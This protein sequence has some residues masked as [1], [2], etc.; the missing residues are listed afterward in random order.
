MTVPVISTKT[1][2][3]QS[4]PNLIARPRLHEKLRNSDSSKLILISAPA[5]YGKTTVLS[6]WRMESG[7]PSAWVSLDKDDN[8]PIRF[9]IYIAKAFN[10][11]STELGENTLSLLRSTRLPSLETI[12]AIL[13]NELSDFHS[14]IQLFLDDY[15]LIEEPAIH[16]LVSFM[17]EHIPQNVKF[18]LACRSDPP[19]QLSRLR[20]LGQLVEI[21]QEDLQ[22]NLEEST[23]LM[24]RFSGLSLD[25]DQISSLEIRT[26]GWVTGLHLA[27][28][29]MQHKPDL[30]GFI[31]EFSG[32]HHYIIDY[33]M[34]EVYSQ[35]TPELRKFLVETS[36][37]DRFTSDLCDE[38]TDRNDSSLFIEKL[39]KGNLFL[40]PLDDHRVWYR[41]HQ[42]FRDFLSS[43][44]SKNEIYDLYTKAVRWLL[45]KGLSGEAVNYSIL[46]GDLDLM[47]EAVSQ[48]SFEALNQGEFMT[49]LRWLHQ[50]PEEVITGNIILSLCKG[51]VLFFTTTHDKA[52]MYLDAAEKILSPNTSAS[53]RGRFL[54]LKAHLAICSDQL[55]PCIGY[56]REALETLDH[57][58]LFFRN[59]TLNI[60]GQVLEMKG[61]VRSAAEIYQ[62]AFDSGWR[63]GDQ[64]GALVAFTNLIFSLNE[65]GMHREAVSLC[66][67]AASGPSR[68][69]KHGIILSDA[70]YL[71]WGLLAYE[72]NDLETAM[73]YTNRGLDLIKV[74]NFPPG[75]LWG[76]N[77]ISR[78]HLRRKEYDQARGVIGEGKKLANELGLNY[79]HGIWFEAMEAQICMETG[80]LKSAGKWADKTGFHSQ[81][82][83]HYWI[84]Y[85]YFIYIRVLLT[86]GRLQ[87]AETLL[88]S[89]EVTVSQEARN[90]KLIS[91]YLL[92]ARLLETQNHS[93]HALEKVVRAMELAAPE[94]YR[95]AFLEDGLHLLPLLQQARSSAPAFVDELLFV[96]KGADHPTL[97]TAELIDPLTEREQEVL[98]LV[99]RGLSN[100]EIADYLVVSLGT[101]KKHLN[102]IFGKLH[103]ESRTQAIIKGREI[104]LI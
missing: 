33:L 97:Q 87:E 45:K 15:H 83:N 17:I 102:N 70:V 89:M 77:I 50:I 38:L 78:I 31:Q 32:S 12:L 93:P 29:S 61:D 39:E 21:R 65:L 72:S 19:L 86:Q 27:A 95:T 24:N 9:L 58:D 67:K 23:E 75:I 81:G 79:V 41:Y 30:D 34:D 7:L 99:S 54:V 82:P 101:I 25:P 57:D 90:R 13:I 62:Q 91:I 43:K 16:S 48:A 69:K 20:A 28:L 49:I 100:R 46:T 76:L 92:Q 52:Q 98:R 64:L 35:Q 18:F 5:G 11:L 22:F 74:V 47:V 103:V 10:E 63:F 68:N 56:S 53:I 3:P 96:L 55:E 40:V 37:L 26:E 6:S 80:D 44:L 4:R 94:N 60:L 73:E 71:V 104:G 8:D 59:L 85:C 88:A 42:L 66:Q 14:T 2:F 84:D 36:I 1:S 51:F